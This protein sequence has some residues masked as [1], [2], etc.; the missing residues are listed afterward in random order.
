MK[1]KQR[2]EK[3]NQRKSRRSS[4]EILTVMLLSSSDSVDETGQSV[5][6]VHKGKCLH[7]DGGLPFL[8]VTEAEKSWVLLLLLAAVGEAG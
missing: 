5:F 8:P 4:T 6:T 2:K 7:F 3:K 1:E